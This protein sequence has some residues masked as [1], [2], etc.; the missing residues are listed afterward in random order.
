MS[1]RD[2]VSLFVRS[3]DEIAW[4][5]T[6]MLAQIL[7]TDRAGIAV[8]VD[9]GIV[10]LTA[11]AGLPGRRTCSP[12]P[13]GSPGTST[14]SSMSSARCGIPSAGVSCWRYS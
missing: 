4:Q 6:E 8:S 1:L 14:A 2:L 9:D 10:T 11:A 3:D 12:S 7:P 5:V 13:P